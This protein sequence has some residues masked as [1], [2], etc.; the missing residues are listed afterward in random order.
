M[1]KHLFDPDSTEPFKL[2]RSGLELFHD[3]PRCFYLD[4][5]LG[6]GRPGGF[7]AWLRGPGLAPSPHASHDGAC[8]SGS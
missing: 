2:S 1:P 7:I 8:R 5:R 3:C 6:I 4:K